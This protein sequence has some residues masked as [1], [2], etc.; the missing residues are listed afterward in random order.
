MGKKKASHPAHLR[1]REINSG[2]LKEYVAQLK[3]QA[4][5]MAALIKVMTELGVELTVIDGATK[6]DRGIEL[7][8]KFNEKLEE[9]LVREKHA[10][11][12]GR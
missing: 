3:D 10:K 6:F 11:K 7:I 12:A 1:R 4:A 9:A 5:E 8:A 2:D